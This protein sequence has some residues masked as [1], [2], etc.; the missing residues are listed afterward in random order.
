MTKTKKTL[1]PEIASEYFHLD[2]PV[3]DP[4]L[5]AI[6]YHHHGVVGVLVGAALEDSSFVWHEGAVDRHGGDH[7]AVLRHQL[8]QEALVPLPGPVAPGNVGTCGYR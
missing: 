5:R 4:I 3:I 7:G 1:Y 8:L 2:K 6:A